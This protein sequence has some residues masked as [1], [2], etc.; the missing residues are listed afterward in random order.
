MNGRDKVKWVNAIG[1]A[2]QKD[3]MS[4]DEAKAFA[5]RMYATVRAV[6]GAPDAPAKPAPK[7]SPHESAKRN[8]YVP[9]PDAVSDDVPF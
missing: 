4:P 8:G 7:T 5:R 2:S 1:G 9:E 3:P 6:S